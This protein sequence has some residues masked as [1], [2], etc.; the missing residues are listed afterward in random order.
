MFRMA[1]S[2]TGEYAE[3]HLAAAGTS[4]NATDAQKKAVVLAAMNASLTRLNGVF[5]RDLSLH[6]NLIDNN[7]AIIFLDKLS[8]PYPDNAGPDDANTGITSVISASNFDMGHL[9]DKKKCEWGSLS[10][11]TV[12]KPAGKRLDSP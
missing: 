1:L 9:L 5:E 2:C 4:P 8:D 10:G 3:Y 12:R 6:F 7:D 11:C